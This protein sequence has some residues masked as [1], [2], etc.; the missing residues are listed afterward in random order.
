MDESLKICIVGAKGQ[1]GQELESVL[2]LK[3]ADIGK[4]DKV[5]E[6]ANVL[7]VDLPELDIVDTGL[8]GAFFSTNTFDVIINCSAFTNVDGCED[9]EEQAYSI[10][11]IGV[12]N[13]AIEASK[14]NAKFVH[15]S[16]DYVFS[17]E[18]ANARI[19][20]DEM[21]PISA[22]GRTKLEGE[23][24][25]LEFCKRTFVLRTSW[26]YGKFGKNFV[27]T[28]L[29]LAD[30]L[31]EV[32]V[33]ADQFGNPTNANDLAYEILEIAK[34][35]DYGIYHVTGEGICTWADLAQKSFELAGKN[36]KV[37]RV[38]TKNYLKDHPQSAPRPH[39][40]A[41]ENKHLKETIGNK[42]RNWEDAL[43]SFIEDIENN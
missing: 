31:D 30:K 34:G 19:E 4:I 7:S 37:K 23:K 12:K 16:T 24:L 2:K 25:A 22:Y 40:S 36:C 28:M 42:M 9:H 41:L 6:G 35:D 39:Y 13:L 3:K 11:A 5:Y 32:S 26:L 1:L 29:G 14:Q 27:F 43:Y 10:N 21:D 17:G 33:V 38:T 8:V 20:A 15:I 18:Y